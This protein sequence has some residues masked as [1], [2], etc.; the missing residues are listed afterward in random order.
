MK[1]TAV[2]MEKDSTRVHKTPYGAP[3][4][5]KTFSQGGVCGDLFIFSESHGKQKHRSTEASISSHD[6]PNEPQQEPGG[7]TQ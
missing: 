1:Q 3:N 2:V 4:S 5:I 6:L 7:Q